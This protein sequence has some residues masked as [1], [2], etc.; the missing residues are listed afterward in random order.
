M[1]FGKL[2][3]KAKGMFGKRGGMESAKKDAEEVKD[4]AA[5]DASLSEKGKE[6]VEA[7]KD[8]GAPGEGA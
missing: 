1:D 8:P 7:I 4:I 2:M 5:G 3:D 6:G